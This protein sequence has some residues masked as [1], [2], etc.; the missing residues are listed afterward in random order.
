MAGKH[1]I[2]EF[3]ELCGM[4]SNADVKED[5][6]KEKIRN[7]I[8]YKMETGALQKEYKKKGEI[9]MKKKRVKFI[10]VF[11][12]TLVCLVGIFSATA[13]G[14]EMIQKILARFHVGNMTITQYEKEL[15]K[16]ESNAGSG[17][18]VA[19]EFKP[20]NS[21]IEEARSVMEVDFAVP[22]WL[23][24]G[25]VYTKSVLHSKNGA[26]LVYSKGE[27]LVSLLITKG[28]N[29]ISTA[30][31]VKSE[32]IS[33]NTVY[34]ANGIVLWGQDGLT[35]ELYQMGEKDFDRDTL[36]KIISTMSTGTVRNDRFQYDEAD[37]N[38]PKTAEVAAQAAEK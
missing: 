27:S 33:G 14:Q 8:K 23:P 35:Y 4:L 22:T 10:A 2:K 17:K 3:N 24:D 13:Y 5:L 7:Q 1:D 6:H 36:G 38:N 21:S 18:R 16:V 20:R 15:P 11:T 37:R 26:E 29:G 12:A 30:G 28:E 25:Y 19:S 32:T 31:E 34:F 9:Y